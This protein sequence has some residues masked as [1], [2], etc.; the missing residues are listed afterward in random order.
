MVGDESEEYIYSVEASAYLVSFDNEDGSAMLNAGAQI[1]G[2][3]EGAPQSIPYPI[4]VPAASKHTSSLLS[5]TVDLASCGLR[6]GLIPLEID[7][8]GLGGAQEDHNLDVDGQTLHLVS[9][10][11]I[12]EIRRKL[13]VQRKPSFA[14]TDVR[15]RPCQG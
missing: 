14:A 3:Q 4:G 11:K 12:V 7:S 9:P 15:K 6:N 10:C 5:P 2:G 8:F 13:I 1:Q